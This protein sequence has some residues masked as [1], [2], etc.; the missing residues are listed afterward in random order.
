MKKIN[1]IVLSF[2]TIFLI[3]CQTNKRPYPS[4]YYQCEKCGEAFEISKSIDENNL[5]C[6]D[7]S[8]EGKVQKIASYKRYG[9]GLNTR[10]GYSDPWEVGYSGPYVGSRGFLGVGFHGGGHHH[11]YYHDDRH[12]KSGSKKSNRPPARRIVNSDKSNSNSA[13]MKRIHSGSSSSH[14]P[15]SSSR[16]PSRSIP[17]KSSN[18]GSS[19][20]S[21]SPSRS[22]PSKSSSSSSKG[23]SG[24]RIYN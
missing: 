20:S 5:S 24:R 19:N 4:A 12:S 11:H 9:S 16:S 6:P 23:S 18:G 14:T 1:Y 22:I 15:S 10:Y 13:P 7:K 17:S 3:S 8:C 2:L 21:R